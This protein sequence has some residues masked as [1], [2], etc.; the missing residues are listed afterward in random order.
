MDDYLDLIIDIFDQ[1]RQH[2]RVLRSL[3]IAGLIDEILKEFDGLDR[4]KPESYAVTLRGKESAL[5]PRQTIGQLD[6]QIH[7]ELVFSYARTSN[8]AAVR[9]VDRAFF[10]ES[11]NDQIFEIRFTP[12]L[13]GRASSDPAHNAQLGVNLKSHPQSGHISRRQ[14]Q[15]LLSN[16][17]YFLETLSANSP[18][19][20]NKRDVPISG[21]A[22]ITSG[23]QV[24]LSSVFIRLTFFHL[25]AGEF[26]PALPLATLKIEPGGRVV[27]IT[28]S[29]FT[30][31]QSGCNLN[32]VED[33]QARSG[34]IRFVD[35]KFV[36]TLAGQ[37]P[38]ELSTCAQI[39]LSAETRLVFQMAS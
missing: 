37:P 7:D 4:S 30:V 21:R 10:Y 25:L 2:A 11:E 34:E 13:I 16:G 9:A 3:T 31:G 23:D 20:I 8:R 5:D 36:A 14:A 17:E 22:K 33:P 38:Q 24:F 12:A 39:V 1:P 35:G 26:D 18:T 32:L 29:P 27:P 15:I 19:F 28:S 6:L